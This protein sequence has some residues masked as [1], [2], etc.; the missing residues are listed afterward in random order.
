MRQTLLVKIQ[1]VFTYYS[2]V[3]QWNEISWIWI[4]FLKC[5]IFVDQTIVVFREKHSRGCIEM[6]KN[7][8]KTK[9]VISPLNLINTIYI[10]PMAQILKAKL[11]WKISC[12]CRERIN[13]YLRPSLF[14]CY[15]MITLIYSNVLQMCWKTRHT[16]VS[17]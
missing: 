11:T 1:C 5:C 10:D 4:W 2:C 7:V 8:V 14:F 15:D 16:H 6:L 17:A 9:H 12:N 3:Y 13:R